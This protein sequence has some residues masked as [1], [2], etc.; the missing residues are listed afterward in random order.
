M[1]H[2]L[3]KLL[4]VP[5]LV[6]TDLDI[7][8]SKQEKKDFVQI[9][10]LQTRTTTNKTIAKYNLT[11][12]IASLSTSHFKDNNLY[13]AFQGDKIE[14]FYATSL[15]EA[16]ILSN[17]SNDILNITIK[18]V[19]PEIYQEI[20]TSSNRRINLIKSSYKLQRKLSSSKSDFANELLYQL[21]I[22]E[23]DNLPELPNYIK[24]ALEWLKTELGFTKDEE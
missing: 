9:D 1:Y 3:I 18:K 10:N 17:Y 13:I 19:K 16:L 12:N 24:D 15:E 14:D 2:H 11:D 22:N 5:T 6:I 4:N 8:R 23:E 7:K 21:S 20:L